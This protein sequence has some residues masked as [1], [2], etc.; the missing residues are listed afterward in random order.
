MAR[1]IRLCIRWAILSVVIVIV[2]AV[3]LLAYRFTH[4][5]QQT[6]AL[7]P[8]ALALQATPQSGVTNIAL[9]GLD[10]ADGGVQRADC[11]MVLSIDGDDV[12]LISLMRDSLVEIEGYGQT[13]LNHAYAYGG[14]EL[15]IATINSNFGLDIAHYAAVDFSQM[16]N[17]IGALGYITID[18]QDYELDELNV[19]IGEYCRAFDM[20]ECT[21]AEAG[22][23][24]LNGIQAMS[25]GRIRKDGTGDDWGRVERQAIV[26]EAMFARVQDMSLTEMMQL[27]VTGIQYVSTD[28]SLSQI[29]S[30]AATAF[31]EGVPTI[32]HTRIP[33][34]GEWSYDDAYIVY[35]LDDAAAQ[36]ADYIYGD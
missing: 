15:A 3:G 21:L 24:N 10:A 12:K 29:A 27:A 5:Y 17:L 33:E 14:A 4:S 35:D 26:M 25:Y 23:Q 34:D 19:F 7:D 20:E 6:D 16:A 8:A 28:L 1:L 22:V 11:I 32:S 13:K 36:I 31:S 18:V 30:I 9:F 2:I